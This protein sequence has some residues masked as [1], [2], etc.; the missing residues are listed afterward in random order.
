MSSDWLLEEGKGIRDYTE[1]S[2]MVV[3]Q[4]G[5]TTEVIETSIEEIRLGYFDD[6]F[7]FQ[8]IEF[9]VLTWYHNRVS[10]VEFQIQDRAMQKKIKVRGG[11]SDFE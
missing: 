3:W 11:Q 10:N 7:S 2:S 8:N 6:K 1:V 9:E 4:N 5:S